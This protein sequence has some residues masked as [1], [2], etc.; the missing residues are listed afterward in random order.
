MASGGE[1]TCRVATGLPAILCR[2]LEAQ[3][4]GQKDLDRIVEGHTRLKLLRRLL[5]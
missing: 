4:L 5:G 1:A 3:D 2:W